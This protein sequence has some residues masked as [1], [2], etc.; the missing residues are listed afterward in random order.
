MFYSFLLTNRYVTICSIHF[1]QNKIITRHT[2]LVILKL[3]NAEFHLICLK[4]INQNHKILQ[5]LILYSWLWI[6]W[7]FLIDNYSINIIHKYMYLTI[8]FFPDLK[9]IIWRIYEIH[10]AERSLYWSSTSALA[11]V[12]TLD[13]RN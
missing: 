3:W 10:K 4:H 2:M 1:L 9:L 13:F 6:Q 7:A 5:L 11:G 8:K 12:W